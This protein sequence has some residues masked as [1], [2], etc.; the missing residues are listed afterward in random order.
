MIAPSQRGSVAARISE[1]ELEAHDRPAGEKVE[2]RRQ[3][4]EGELVGAR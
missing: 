1:L 2:D 4:E 3:R